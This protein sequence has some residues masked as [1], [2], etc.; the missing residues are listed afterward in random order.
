VAPGSL[1]SIKQVGIDLWMPEKSWEHSDAAFYI[2]EKMTG[3]IK[4]DTPGAI[5]WVRRVEIRNEVYFH[6]HTASAL[7]Y[8][9]GTER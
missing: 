1:G 4:K 7:K 3:C 5:G 6:F 2:F 8:G 9:V